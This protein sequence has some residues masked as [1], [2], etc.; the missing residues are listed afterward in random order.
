MITTKHEVDIVN[1]NDFKSFKY[2]VKLLG[3]SSVRT[4]VLTL[5]L[6]NKW[7][8]TSYLHAASYMLL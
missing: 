7:Y 5:E 6:K 3:N 1:I 4:D 2:K 8:V